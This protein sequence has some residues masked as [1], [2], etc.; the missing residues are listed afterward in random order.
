MCIHRGSPGISS[1]GSSGGSPSKPCPLTTTPLSTGL[2]IH[3]CPFAEKGLAQGR[4]LLSRLKGGPFLWDKEE[5]QGPQG[6]QD[7]PRT[8]K[9]CLTEPTSQTL[10]FGGPC[11]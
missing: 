2:L 3:Q 4:A 9:A 1:S 10:P 6:Q 5:L 8:C 11:R 7:T